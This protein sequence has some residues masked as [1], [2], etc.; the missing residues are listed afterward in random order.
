MGKTAGPLSA[1]FFRRP[2][3]GASL[4]AEGVEHLERLFP[5]F[6]SEDRFSRN[7]IGERILLEDLSGFYVASMRPGTEQ[8][9]A[10]RLGRVPGVEYAEASAPRQ[11]L[12]VLPNDTWFSKQWGLHNT[13]QT[14]CSPYSLPA[15]VADADMNLPE[16]WDITTG[17]SS[18][19]VGILDTGIWASQ[20]DFA[21][22]VNL[23]D[24]KSFTPVDPVIGS[25]A[26]VPFDCAYTTDDLPVDD[27]GHGTAVTGI[28]A[29]SGNNSM[30]VAGIAWGVTPI[31]I[32]VL[33][34]AGFTEG[35]VS[36][37]GMDW[38]RSQSIPILNMSYAGPVDSVERAAARNAFYSGQL[39]V[40]AI[41]N[42]NN[43]SKV[44]PA[45]YANMV[46]AVGAFY[47]NG[48]RWDEGP[49]RGSNFGPWID[50]SA[51]GGT[52]I[53]TT[54]FG[55]R[56]NNNTYYDLQDCS[57]AFG[58]TSSAAPAVA[59]V[60]SLILS[61]YPS[62]LG[63][64]LLQVMERTA[65]DVSPTGFDDSTGYGHVRADASLNYLAAPKEIAHLQAT[66]MSVFS[67]QKL[68]SRTFNNIPGL[69]SGSYLCWR[70]QMRKTVTFPASYS[71]TPD[72]WVRSSGSLGANN[73]DPYD[74]NS[75]VYS[76][77]IVPGTLTTTG[78][79]VETYVYQ[80]LPAGSPAVW[81]PGG[82]ADASVALTLVGSVPPAAVT[83][84]AVDYVGNTLVGLT[85]TAPGDDGTTGTATSYDLRY[86]SSPIT[87]GNFA[88]ATSAS[89]P[90]PA[91]AG[92]PQSAEVTGL[93]SCHTYYFAIKAIDDVGN[94]G[95]LSNV[96][97]TGTSCGPGPN[98]SR[99]EMAPTK[100]DLA[101]L[102]ANP[103]RGRAVRFRLDLPPG[104]SREA[105]LA[106]FDLTGRRV[107]GWNADLLRDGRNGMAWDL[108]SDAGRI[109]GS[110]VYFMR[111]RVG[112]VLLSRSLVVTR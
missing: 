90:A 26:A 19:R 81:F 99:I 98:A 32:K 48:R 28:V 66:N 13:A 57:N 102:E 85:W 23:S 75:E 11:S 78:C 63:E 61:R 112:S 83:D 53:A 93:Q 9:A 52:L 35:C 54:S 41:G 56:M 62:L 76:G 69:A 59:G 87:A 37:R 97:S 107:R 84:L 110:G 47:G 104:G 4:A 73:V 5:D 109:V 12:S 108:T 106:V 2:G 72:A 67:S 89:A 38:A 105:Q 34:C 31:A 101:V 27:N 91:A 42:D 50:L 80:I 10:A 95:A 30:G 14:L 55:A 40:A 25:C 45:G 8:G 86:S 68:L 16:A 64:D 15:L 43:S 7:L 21:G 58:G 100:P 29:A 6:R 79:V 94:A 44:Y 103:I 71:S 82:T 36:A 65:V 111:L 70:Y 39:L 18:V 88:S 22:R 77:S 74:Y 51:P 20:Q 60:A 3:L 1:F 92:T 96:P 24:G 49:G 46:C 17:S 33:D